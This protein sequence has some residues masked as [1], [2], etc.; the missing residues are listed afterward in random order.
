MQL[1]AFPDPD[2]PHDVCTDASDLQLGA[3]IKQRGT[4]VAFFSRKLSA[5]QIKCPAI[6][7][8]MLCI[9]EVLEECRPIPQ[10]AE[11]HVCTDH[12]NLTRNAI[13]SNRIMTWRMLCEEFNPVFHC[14]E[15][16]N[17]VEADALSRLPF[18]PNT[19]KSPE[20]KKGCRH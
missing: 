9:V 2:L 18:S 19:S 1:L 14:I 17:N 4:T 10:G 5:A 12:V 3:V 8:E 20:E 11:I 7:E 6:D 15:G 13:A 16:Q